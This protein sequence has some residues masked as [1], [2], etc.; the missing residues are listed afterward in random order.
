MSIT[1]QLDVAKRMAHV[2]FSRI[3]EIS[4]KSNE[5][6]NKGKK[7]FNLTLG[8]SN[9]DTPDIIIQSAIDAM[10]EG[11]THYSSNYGIYDLRVAIAKKLK[12]ENN[13]D[14]EPDEIL[15]TMGASEGI[16]STFLALLDPG[17]EVLIPSPAWPGYVSAAKIAGAIPVEVPLIK[18]KNRLGIDFKGLEK[19]ITT[20]TKILVIN[21]PSNPCGTVMNRNELESVAYI[22]K[23]YKLLI[24][25]DEIYEKVID[26]NFDHI[27][28]ASLKD[29]KERTITINGFSKGYAMS[30]WR[31]GYV[32]AKRV[33]IKAIVRVK[34]NNTI[35]LPEFTQLAALTAI[36]SAKEQVEIMRKSYM[37]RKKLLI[38]G[39]KI[40]K[41]IDILTSEGAF[42]FLIDIT[43]LG[44]SS[45]DLAIDILEKTGVATVPG[46]FFGSSGEGYLRLS[47][48]S[49]EDVLNHAVE[50]L[51]HYF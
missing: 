26:D 4:D 15:I 24:L 29:M 38:K 14:A 42:Y 17:D 48:T 47:Y 3:S 40:N 21:T 22:A 2:T 23:K 12:L 20:R 25:A 49:S 6:S 50:R 18:R 41:N 5:L 33:F 46:I 8:E 27:S 1:H 10:R 7:T 34:Q 39:L 9:F 37:H 13:I 36:T 51:T 30:G 16:F 32:H 35:S 31:I 44:I 28:I 11:K 19:K 45:H 43:S